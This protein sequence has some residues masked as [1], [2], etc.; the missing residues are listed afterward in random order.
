[1]MIEVM[2]CFFSSRMRSRRLPL[3]SS[4]RAAVGSSRMSSFTFF[5][6]AL[7][8]STSCCLPTPMSATR[9]SRVV[10]QTDPA[11]QLG[12]VPQGLVPV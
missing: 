9:V 8:I 10:V 1:M 12:G 7:A 6:S 3:S 11:Q 2:P 5:D 4:F